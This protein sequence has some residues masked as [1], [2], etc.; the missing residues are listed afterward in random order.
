[1]IKYLLNMIKWFLIS[2]MVKF[3]HTSM[4]LWGLLIMGNNGIIQKLCSITLKLF[5]YFKR[6][7]MMPIIWSIYPRIVVAKFF[8]TNH[9]MILN[10]YIKSHNKLDSKPSKK[11]P[12]KFNWCMWSLIVVFGH[13]S[14]TPLP[15]IKLKNRYL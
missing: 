11:R 4:T 8:S 1:M 10:Q 13:P 2:W 12:K 7:L 3:I 15:H 14:F 9:F 5:L 6:L